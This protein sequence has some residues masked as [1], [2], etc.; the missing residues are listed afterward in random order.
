MYFVSFFSG[1]FMAYI[2]LTALFGGEVTISE[3]TYDENEAVRSVAIAQKFSVVTIVLQKNLSSILLNISLKGSRDG[4]Q[5]VE[6]SL[7]FH[8]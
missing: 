5:N 4:G 3:G 7:L 1:E 8:P 6:V 2:N